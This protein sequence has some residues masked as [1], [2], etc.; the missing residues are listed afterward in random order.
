VDDRADSYER[1]EFLGDGVLGL[2]VAHE[3]YRRFPER[4]E[5]DLARIRAHAVSRQSCAEVARG[6]GLDGDLA[7]Q[8]ERCERQADLETLIRSQAVMA[9]LV[10]SAIGAAYLEYG[11]EPVAAAVIG[12]FAGPIEFAV[13][14]HVDHKTVLQEALARLGASVTYRLMETSGPPHRRTFTTAAM[15][16]GRE[17]GRG[18]G[19]S[20]KASE[21]AA[22]REALAA[23]DAQ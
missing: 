21:Q 5:G 12:A 6:I 3:L 20:K 11:L 16:D 8:A 13:E 7:A 19:P 14:R 18:S 22:A 1:L 2:A 4:P 10:E 15:V 23:L 9:A 17:L